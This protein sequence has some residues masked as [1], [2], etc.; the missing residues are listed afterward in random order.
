MTVEKRELLYMRVFSTL[1][2][3]SIENKSCMRVSVDKREFASE[4]SQLS[5]PGQT[6]RRVV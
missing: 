4:I 1:V 3:R 5:C 2:S 6:R